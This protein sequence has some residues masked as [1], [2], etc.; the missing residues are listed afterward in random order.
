MAVSAKPRGDRGT[1]ARTTMNSNDGGADRSDA[2]GCDT[3]TPDHSGEERRPSARRRGSDDGRLAWSE[4]ILFGG[5]ELTILSTPAFAALVT[6]QGVYP[7]AAPLAGLQALAVGSVALAAFRTRAVDVG[8]WPRRG[9]FASLP[10][11][12][13][14]FSVLFFAATMGVAVAAAAAGTWWATLLGGATQTIGLAA[15]PTVYG[16]VHGEP[17]R[18]PVARA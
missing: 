9:E 6:L 4:E 2:D 13:T 17:L 16:L 7:D 10:L 5:M 15:F 18:D 1:P 11:R 3:S 14:Y 8:P 12:V